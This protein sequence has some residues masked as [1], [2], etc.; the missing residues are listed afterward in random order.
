MSC[1]LCASVQSPFII[2]ENIPYWSC[3]DCGLVAKDKAH[4]P[5]PDAEKAHYDSHNNDLNDLGYKQ[6]LERLL[7]PLMDRVNWDN[8]PITALDFGAG[9]GPL[10]AKML[11]D[12]GCDTS[13]YD[14]FY[15]P[16]Q[17]VLA[18]RYD[19][20]TAT[21]VI[22]HFHNPKVMF[23]HLHAM[24]KPKGMLAVM[25][26]VLT[27]DIDFKQWHYHRDPT[28]VVFYRPETFA[29]IAEHYGLRLEIPHKNVAIFTK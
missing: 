17:S 14:P 16:D 12:A 15:A 3:P 10:L 1:P 11:A 9:P 7:I 4:F 27:D 5:S 19:I 28:H 6:F 25:T 23:D 21:E 8:A 22:E 18:G 26:M 2:I 24:L 20:I 13:I 29:H